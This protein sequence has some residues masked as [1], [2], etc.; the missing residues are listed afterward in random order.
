MSFYKLE[1]SDSIAK[2]H[3]DQIAHYGLS[4]AKIF[5]DYKVYI[6]KKV[7]ILMV[8]LARW[9]EQK[10]NLSTE[11]ISN[12]LIEKY[13]QFCSQLEPSLEVFYNELS[14]ILA[15]PEP[16]QSK[17]SMVC[18]A[19]NE[20]ILEEEILMEKKEELYIL[21]NN[22]KI[23]KYYLDALKRRMEALKTCHQLLEK[24]EIALKMYDLDTKLKRIELS[25]PVRKEAVD[26]LLNSAGKDVFMTLIN[27][28]QYARLEQ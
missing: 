2:L 20:D 10:T 3:E 12:M 8:Y 4:S 22:Y 5:M 19:A 21:E 27:D 26:K 14:N 1:V 24:I 16:I 18:E 13:K 11:L 28:G 6:E 17:F 23:E 7:K 25:N 15:P 9:Y